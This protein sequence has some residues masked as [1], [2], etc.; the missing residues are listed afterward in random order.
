M[1]PSLTSYLSLLSCLLLVSLSLA[2]CGGGN[3]TANGTEGSANM[4]LK[5]AIVNKSISFFPLYIAQEENFIKAQG[6]TLDPDTVPL[7]GSGA[8]LS[9]AVEA[10]SIDV[11]IGGLTDVFTISR[12]D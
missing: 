6:L 9:S 3:P 11:G 12:V 10:N 1:K 5:V 2:S 7:L 8:K 4:T